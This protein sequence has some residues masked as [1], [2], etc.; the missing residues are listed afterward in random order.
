MI[1]AACIGYHVKH[2]GFG[3]FVYYTLISNFLAAF[4]TLLL[5][6]FGPGS[7]TA[8]FRYL[9][10][11]MMTMTFL[12]VVLVLVPMS[13][14]LKGELFSGTQ[15]FYH[16]FCPVLTFVSYLLWEPHSRA[17]WLPVAV[18]LVYGLVMM[19]L[20]Y[21]GKI[22]GPYPFLK[23]KEQ[24]LAK[25]LMWIAAMF[26]LIGGIAFGVMKLADCGCDIIQM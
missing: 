26:A 25:T 14:D 10:V 1:E 12:V 24:G 22:D 13:G 15:F 8:A 17:F 20:N 21:K 23:V 7:F 2:A 9:S 19:Y 18:T 5:L 4:S 6:I 3:I 16:L 11:C